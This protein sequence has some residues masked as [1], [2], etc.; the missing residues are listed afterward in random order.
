MTLSEIQLTMQNIKAAIE[1]KQQLVE[2][3]QAEVAELKHQRAE[4]AISDKLSLPD[5]QAKLDSIDQ[6]IDRLEHQLELW[7]TEIEL[8]EQRLEPLGQQKAE[9]KKLLQQQ[10]KLITP[11]RELAEKFLVAVGQAQKANEELDKLYSAYLSLSKQTGVDEVLNTKKFCKP[12]NGYLPELLRVLR[13][14]FNEGIHK[15]RLITVRGQIL[16]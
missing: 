16:I 12:S 2:K 3:T 15:P 6:R 9:L 10:Q 7:P 11:L 1:G 13:E 14:E 8:L 5:R 4:V